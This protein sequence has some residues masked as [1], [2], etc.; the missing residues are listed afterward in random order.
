[1]CFPVLEFNLRDDERPY[2]MVLW[3]VGSDDDARLRKLEAVN[4]EAS[5]ASPIH[6]QTCVFFM[7]LD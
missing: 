3:F 6:I 5:Q 4:W 2:E 1:M 7:E